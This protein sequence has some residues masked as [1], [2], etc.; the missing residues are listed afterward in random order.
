MIQVTKWI[1][2]KEYTWYKGRF[3]K[4]KDWLVYTKVEIAKELGVS[5]YIE[6]DGTGAQALFREKLK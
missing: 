6:S 2:P 1:N 5:V 3:V 4:N